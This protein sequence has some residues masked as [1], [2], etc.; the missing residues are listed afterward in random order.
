MRLPPLR[1]LYWI[2][3]ALWHLLRALWHGLRAVF[4]IALA[5]PLSFAWR[6]D[7]KLR[8]PGAGEVVD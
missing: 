3:V 6:A 8:G 7:F 5:L 4:F 1:A 2:P